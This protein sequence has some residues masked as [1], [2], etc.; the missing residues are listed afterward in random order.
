M[1]AFLVHLEYDARGALRDRGRLLMVHLFPLAFFFLCGA[2][3][4]ALNPFFRAAMLPGMALFAMM[5]A[6]LLAAPSA[7][8]QARESGVFRSFRVNG[9]PSSSVLSV[10]VIGTAPHVAVAIVVICVAGAGVFGGRVPASLAGFA[11]AALLSY[12]TLAG[13]GSLIGVAADRD[14][15]AILAAQFVFVPSCLLG[16]LMV[17]ERVLPG[18]LQ[19]IA[20][21][22]PATHCMRAFAWLGGMGDGSAPWPSLLVLGSSIALSFGLAGALFEWDTRANRPGRRSY[23][24]FLA[25]APYV[26][27]ALARV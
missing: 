5:S 7:L 14:S 8:V 19:Q 2:F 24:A 16:G 11:A 6:T 17:P 1:K 21:L 20:L 22:L 23:V 25:A 27:A 18:A 3:M 9:V 26:V 15:T 13:I 12:A 10:P 4:T